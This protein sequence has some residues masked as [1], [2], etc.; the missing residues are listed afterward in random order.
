MFIGRPDR[1]SS[2]VVASTIPPAA[3]PALAKLKSRLSCDEGGGGAPLIETLG[4]TVAEPPYSS[5]TSPTC[6]VI[7]ASTPGLSHSGWCSGLELLL[8]LVLLL[9][10][11]L[12]SYIPVNTT[13]PIEEDADPPPGAGPKAPPPPEWWWWWWWC[14]VWV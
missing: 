1:V 4:T 6:G 14:V 8:L 13:G 2:V 10:L 9:L 11:L 3:A 7:T 12:G 5:S